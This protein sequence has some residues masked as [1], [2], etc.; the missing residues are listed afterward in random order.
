MDDDRWDA[1]TNR[2]LAIYL[3]AILLFF[4]VLITDGDGFVYLIDGANL[5]FHEAGHVVFGFFGD[6]L[7]LYGG[8]LGQLVFPAVVAASFWR[9]GQPLS[10]AGGLV[11]F[12]ENFLNIARYMADARA[13]ELPLVGGGDHD[14]TNIFSRWDALAHDTNIAGVVR[15]IGWLGMVAASAWVIWRWH[16][17]RQNGRAPVVT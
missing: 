3:F 8:T 2:T 10:F 13:Q 15:I 4:T 9:K 14:W 12:F 11:W 17:D 7:G 6:T 16:R 1:V 5:L